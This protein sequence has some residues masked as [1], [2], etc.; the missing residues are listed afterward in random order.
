MLKWEPLKEGK[1]KSSL[2]CGCGLSAQISLAK[3]NP[4]FW[5]KIHHRYGNFFAEMAGGGAFALTR[6]EYFS[7]FDFDIA[8]ALHPP[9]D[10]FLFKWSYTNRNDHIPYL[11][12]LDL[13]LTLINC[14]AEYKETVNMWGPAEEETVLWFYEAANFL[15]PCLLCAFSRGLA[16]GIAVCVAEVLLPYLVFL[17]D[18]EKSFLWLFKV[19]KIIL[20]HFILHRGG[21]HHCTCACF[22]GIV[23]LVQTPTA[24][25]SDFVKRLLRE[26]CILF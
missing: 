18:E 21:L 11:A 14:S 9:K 15:Q 2:K 17:V 5:L 6:E 3:V 1:K 22:H 20:R 19:P 13:F 8:S 25:A 4:D 16:A 26:L 23:L 10:E 24:C 12:A 7:W